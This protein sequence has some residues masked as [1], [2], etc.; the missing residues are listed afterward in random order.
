MELLSHQP[1][2]LS[3]GKVYDHYIWCLPIALFCICHFCT[4]RL[5]NKIELEHIGTLIR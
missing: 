2:R 4:H 3:K 1:T 5:W